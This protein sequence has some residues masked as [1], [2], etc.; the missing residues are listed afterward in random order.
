MSLLKSRVKALETEQQRNYPPGGQH[1][2][3]VVHVP[4]EIPS[5]SWHDWLASQPCACGVVGCPS[6]R[7]GLLIPTRCQTAEE[8]E[9]RYGRDHATQPHVPVRKE[10]LCQWTPF[11]SAQRVATSWPTISESVFDAGSPGK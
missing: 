9:P 4:P 3:S 5:E 8:W 7:I 2:T 11:R 6:R 10:R 1:F